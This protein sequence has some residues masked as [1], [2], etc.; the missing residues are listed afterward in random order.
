MVK[1]YYERHATVDQSIRAEVYWEVSCKALIKILVIVKKKKLPPK[2]ICSKTFTVWVYSVQ[3]YHLCNLAIKEHFKDPVSSGMSK[4]K[5]FWVFSYNWYMLSWIPSTLWSL[6]HC[7]REFTDSED[8]QSQW[9]LQC[10][11]CEA[12][13]KP[14]IQSNSFSEDANDWTPL[15]FFHTL[16]LILAL[17]RHPLNWSHQHGTYRTNKKN[18]K[19]CRQWEFVL[20]LSL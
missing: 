7:L 19:L 9:F 5:V 4:S 15:Y 16:P 3:W 1:A 17:A 2:N 14:I 12:T 10:K 8:Q 6:L 20:N 11:I 18:G 13:P